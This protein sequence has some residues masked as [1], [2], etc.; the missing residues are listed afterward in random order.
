MQKF[1]YSCSTCMGM[2]AAMPPEESGKLKSA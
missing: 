2:E 1:D